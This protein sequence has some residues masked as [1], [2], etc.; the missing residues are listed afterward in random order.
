MLMWNLNQNSKNMKKNIFKILVLL[1]ISCP[2]MGQVGVN[3]TNPVTTLD[4]NGDINVTGK[5]H[6]SGTD[7]ALGDPG[8]KN[9]ALTSN[10]TTND[11]SWEEVKIPVGYEGGLYLTAVEALNDRVG[12]NLFQTGS[13]T[14]AQNESLSGNWTEI[15]GLTKQITVSHSV[16]KVH[17]QFQTTAQM[18]FAGS[19]SFSC[20][21]FLD[22]QLKG[23][24]V[25]IIRGSAGSYNVFNIN[26]SFNNISVGNHTF[27]VACRGRN[28]TSTSGQIAIGTA[29]TP[30]SLNADM[31][32]SALNIFVLEDLLD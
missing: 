29:I 4:V 31:S 26:S 28:Y 11:V 3:T 6:V 15:P 12:L 2:V 22:N 9:K 32:Q 20:G 21:I 30:S 5:I 7:S 25:D 17:V 13:T 8:D 16:N 1:V 10:G 27:K 24:R 23:T 14:Y 18:N 19:A